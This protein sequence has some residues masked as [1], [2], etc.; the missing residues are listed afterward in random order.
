[1]YPAGYSVGRTCRRAPWPS[2]VGRPR[3]SA[4][5]GMPPMTDPMEPNEPNEPFEPIPP[6]PPRPAPVAKKG[7]YRPSPLP[8]ILTGLGL[9]AVFV[10]TGFVLAQ[11]VPKKE[12]APPPA[13]SAAPT[14]A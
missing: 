14:P 5:L 7:P 10:G 8:G 12:E 11:M 13:A 4:S 9:G 2:R 6:A 3:A 1:M